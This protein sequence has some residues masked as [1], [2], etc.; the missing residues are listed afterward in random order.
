M[1]TAILALLALSACHSVGGI[2]PEDTAFPTE[3]DTD[4]DTDTDTDADGDTD[5]DTDADADTDA[6]VDLSPEGDYE[7]DVFLLAENDW[8]PMEC[9]GLFELAIESS[10]DATGYAICELDWFDLEGE[11]AGEVSE[12]EFMGYWTINMGGH[13][14][15]R[16]FEIELN[17]TV[18]GGELHVDIYQDLDYFI[19]SGTMDGALLD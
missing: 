12:N 19:A 5:T 13:G 6:D 15:D 17:G 16:E 14:G 10:G 18:E 9:N 7:G 8:Y 4:T 3:G 2:Q 1:R 11:M